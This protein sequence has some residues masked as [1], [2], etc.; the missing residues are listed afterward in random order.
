MLRIRLNTFQRMKYTSI[1]FFH[2]QNMLVMS[3][4]R[5]NHFIK[6]LSSVFSNTIH[7]S[8]TRIKSFIL[9]PELNSQSEE[10]NTLNLSNQI[11]KISQLNKEYKENCFTSSLDNPKNPKNDKFSLKELEDFNSELSKKEET[12][13]NS[14]I[15][16]KNNSIFKTFPSI[17]KKDSKHFTLKEN[18]KKTNIK[19]YNGREWFLNSVNK[20]KL[21]SDLEEKRKLIKTSKV[22]FL[23]FKDLI[24]I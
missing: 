6:L 22:V 21:A 11:K 3:Q 18:D 24:R 23:L 14:T 5:S 12:E 20:K 9:H 16:N 7:Y 10:F 8:F 17:E 13:L 15:D 19:K 4:K 1:P 2:W